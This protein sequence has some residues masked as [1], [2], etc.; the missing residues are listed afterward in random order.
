[1][2]RSFLATGLPPAANLATAPR[3]VDLEACPPV[4][5]YTS[6]SSTRMFTLAPEASTWSKP[7]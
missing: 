5:E 2:A 4:L 6:V 1:M 7:P 3:G